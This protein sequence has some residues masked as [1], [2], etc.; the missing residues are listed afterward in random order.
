M[1]DK[2]PVV[3]TE[4]CLYCLRVLRS[5]SL[6]RMGAGIGRDGEEKTSVWSTLASQASK[7]LLWLSF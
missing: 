5:L 3:S 2:V 4:L 6:T 7:A 1:G